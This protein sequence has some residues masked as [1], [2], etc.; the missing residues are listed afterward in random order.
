MK[1]ILSLKIVLIL[2][3]VSLFSYNAFASTSKTTLIS[4]NI[5]VG[6][7]DVSNLS[8]VEALKLLKL[9]FEPKLK[10]SYITLGYK[11]TIW[12]LKYS[13]LGVTYNYSKAISDALKIVRDTPVKN[14]PI[15]T[16]TSI[17]TNGSID[18][19]TEPP[20]EIPIIKISLIYSYNTKSI[21]NVL[22]KLSKSVA[23]KP[24]NAKL[25]E[26]GKKFTIIP[27][28][29]GLDLDRSLTNKTILQCIK[30]GNR[31]K[32][33]ITTKIVTPKFTKDNLMNIHD[34]LGEYTTYFDPNYT[35][36]VINIKL[37]AKNVTN[38]IVMP[39]E[40]LSIDNAMGPRVASLGYLPA[41]VIIG[42]KLVDGIA[43]GICQV[44][45]TLYNATLLSNLKIVER[46]NHSLPS[47]YVKLGRDATVNGGSKDLKF[48]N[49]TS[50]PIYI[51]NEVVKDHIR[52]TIYGTKSNPSRSVV[53]KTKI[54]ASKKPT[55]KYINDPTLPKGKVVSEINASTG[56]TV[57]SFREVYEG[58]KLLYVESLFLDKYPLVNGIKR[59]G[60]KAQ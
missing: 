39:G 15:T 23:I 9:N 17:T 59:I 16:D 20:V 46:K 41:H 27:E 32:V 42:N 58:K 47:T 3:I 35:N 5:Y 49:N 53:I 34:K 2:V 38:L 25:I 26:N 57:A 22:N 1:R 51:V 24:I 19:T 31:S 48:Q 21:N 7:I 60:T 40:T 44:S 12:K 43:G 45:T 54:L 56:Y 13:E 29:N 8:E 4:E 33:M 11:N 52:F 14:P 37:A 18:N 10:A 36:R 6:G 50:S 55:T 28:I 30:N